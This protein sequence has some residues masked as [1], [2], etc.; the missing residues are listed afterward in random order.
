MMKKIVPIIDFDKIALKS[1]QSR[2]RVLDFNQTKVWQ[3]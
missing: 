1:N 2:N 3:K